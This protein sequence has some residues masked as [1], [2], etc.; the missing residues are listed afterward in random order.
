MVAQKGHSREFECPIVFLDD[1]S[2]D[3]HPLLGM[4]GFFSNFNK[5]I[6]DG[7]SKKIILEH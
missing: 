1:I 2:K 7:Q 5:V 3:G 4:G 6:F